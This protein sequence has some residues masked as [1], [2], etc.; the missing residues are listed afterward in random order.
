M[1]SSHFEINRYLFGADNVYKFNLG[2][3]SVIELLHTLT[4]ESDEKLDLTS[5]VAVVELPEGVFIHTKIGELCSI[6]DSLIEDYMDGE[7][8]GDFVEPDFFYRL[9]STYKTPISEWGD[10]TLVK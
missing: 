9:T 3:D 6:L 10:K 4:N 7:K 5:G 8:V 2:Y 1:T